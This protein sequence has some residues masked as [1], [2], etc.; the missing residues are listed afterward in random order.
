M[1]NTIQSLESFIQTIQIMKTAVPVDLSV[2]VC[3]LEEFLVYYPGKDINLS[4]KRGQ[5]LHYEEPLA[6][7][8]R[9]NKRLQAEV[10]PEF[11]GFAFVGSATPLHDET[12]KVIG[13]IAVQVRKQSELIEISQ[14]IATFLANADEQVGAIVGASKDLAMASSHLMQESQLAEKNVNQT[15]DILNLMKR[16]A[17]QTN[18]LGLNAA[19]EAARA[20]EKGRGFEVVA[21]EI[22]RFSKDT[23][24]STQRIRKTMEQIHTATENMVKTIA[25][26]TEVSNEQSEAIRQTADFIK[27]I[28]ELSE[29]L[30]AFAQKL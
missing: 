26:I 17:D 14:N 16:M 18:L 15:N 21:G 6:V 30:N 5:K 1:K 9:T 22:R 20:G 10:P 23:I 27:E 4:I 19:I 12:G 24:E 28:K 3:D 13:G 2:A 29:K 25:N 11:Y 7:A 8:L